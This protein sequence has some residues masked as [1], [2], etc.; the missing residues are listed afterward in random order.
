VTETDPFD[1]WTAREQ[2]AEALIPI[3]GRL[4]REH[5]VT[6]T[7][8][9]KTL[10]SKSAVSILKAHRFARQVEGEELSVHETK[11][12]I[13]LIADLQPGPARID[14]GAIVKGFK[15]S[16]GSDLR[17]Y[18]EEQ[19][20]PALGAGKQAPSGP[21]DV[22]LYGFGRIGRL[23]AR[24][25]I[26]KAESNSGLRLRAVVVRRSGEN[27]LQ[28]R[29]SLLRRDSIHGAFNG[30]ILVDEARD[31]ITANGQAIRF[32]YSNDPTAIDYT[33][34]GIERAILIDNTGRWRDREGLA[35]HLRP[36]IDKVVLTAPGKGDVPNIVHGV[37]HD[38]VDP[39]ERI[40]SCASCTTN[41]I[42][43]PIKAMEDR[44][45]IVSGHVETVHSFTNDQ[46]LADNY[47]KADRRGRAAT[48]NLVITETGAASAIKKALPDL[49]AHITGNAIRVPTPDVSIAVLNLR[50]ARPTTREEVLEHLREVSLRGPLKRAIDFTTAKDAVSTDFLGSRS[51]SIVDGNATIVHDDTAI[52][53]LWYDNEFG[54]STQVVRV[55]QT[56]S[57][58][59][60]PTLPA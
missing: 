56:I 8:H 30:S 38:T 17:A 6:I 23:V 40:L 43:P 28:K 46:N 16:G 60:V 32:I 37:N 59:E 4:H 18:V 50:L 1:R 53:Y 27:D 12:V 34:Y 41:A 19:L 13:E 26:E 24:I 14:V 20:A 2:E 31:T 5:S 45:G 35:Q 33:E 54:Y 51:A 49:Q 52:L 57:G 48:L 55:V 3:I 9:S 7:V 29:A 42:V 44:F 22:V 25:L 15:A 11:P 58:N 36:G 21:R 47:H 39:A 10:V